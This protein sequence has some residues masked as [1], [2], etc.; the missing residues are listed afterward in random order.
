MTCLWA[1]DLG[2]GESEKLGM[3]LI[4]RG[5][6]CRV[7]LCHWSQHHTALYILLS[8]IS[9]HSGMLLNDKRSDNGEAPVLSRR[10]RGA[11]ICKKK[12]KKIPAAH[13]ETARVGQATRLYRSLHHLHV[14]TRCSEPAKSTH[15]AQLVG[16]AASSPYKSSRLW[17]LYAVSWTR[18][19]G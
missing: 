10:S 6:Q 16:D 3:D 19:R 8:A 5:S 14:V 17:R 12:K 13:R 1:I 9:P 4:C 2:L 15:M 7:V 11:V 18:N